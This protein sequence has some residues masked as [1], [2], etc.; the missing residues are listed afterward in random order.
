MEV[1]TSS[2]LDWLLRVTQSYE[3]DHQETLSPIAKLNTISVL[4]SLVVNLDWPLHELDVKNV[5]LNEDLEQDVY[6][7]I[8]PAFETDATIN[9][10][11]KLKKSL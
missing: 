10:V 6:M 3:I 2:R 8:P 7:E 5:F 4:L 9:K 1:W 11:C